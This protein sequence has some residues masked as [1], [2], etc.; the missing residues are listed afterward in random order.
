MRNFFTWNRS[1]VVLVPLVAAA[2]GGGGSGL[3]PAQPLE[4]TP[5]VLSADTPIAVTGGRVQGSLSET[6]P[7]I[8][9]FKGVPYAAP[10]VGDL[11]W[12]PPVAVEPWDD[13]RDATV[14][15]NRCVQGGRNEE[16]QSEDCLVLN[17]Y[18]PR[19][20]E[21]PLPVMVW[22]HGG[23]YT[24]G[25][26][27]YSTYEGTQLAAR[28]VVLVSINYRLN[29][30][31]FYAHPALSAESPY[32]ASGNQGIQDMV[33]SLVWVQDNIASFDGDPR[34]VTIFG[35]SAGAG[36]VMSL[37]VVPQAEGLYHGA[38]AESN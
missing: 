27:S 28:G 7:D 32:D 9:T 38:I 6:N 25:T 1:L 37:M 2:C 18:A 10:P 14:F 36:A 29:V 20:V 17:V 13:V 22:I 5:T 34:R 3:A 30:F 8:I 12:K 4:E 24:G 16:D 11:R 21:E 26:G 23:G 19:E 31:G 15:G 33:A 35:E